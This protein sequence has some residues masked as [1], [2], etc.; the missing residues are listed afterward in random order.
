MM[1][2]TYVVPENLSFLIG[3]EF[4]E[5][6]LPEISYKR[7]VL[8]TGGNHS[9]LKSSRNGHLCVD[10]NPQSL[11]ALRGTG[12]QTVAAP[13]PRSL[14]PRSIASRFAQTIFAC[15]ATPSCVGG[16]AF[17]ANGRLAGAQNRPAV[18]VRAAAE[19]LVTSSHARRLAC[20]ACSSARWVTQCSWCAQGVCAICVDPG[21][22]PKCADGCVDETFPLSDVQP[23][24][25]KQMRKGTDMQLRAS[26]KHVQAVTI[27]ERGRDARSNASRPTSPTRPG[28]AR[29]RP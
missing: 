25:W 20:T 22:L 9:P 13:L 5:S 4:C 7:R 10:L 15:L 1:M 23:Q 2:K 6:H 21:Q 16:A 29:R 3:R 12:R 28:T 14:R 11:M 27:T 19:A 8:T 17:S 26:L 24:S 18:E